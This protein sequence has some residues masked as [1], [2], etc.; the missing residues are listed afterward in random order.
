M[1]FGSLSISCSIAIILGEV[2]QFELEVC[3]YVFWQFEYKLQYSN[4]TRRG[5]GI[6]D[7]I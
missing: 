1:Y 3:L 4:Y 2:W 5:V 7:T 6:C